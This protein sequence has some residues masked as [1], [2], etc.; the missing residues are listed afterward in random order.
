M[1]TNEVTALG[2]TTK[3]LTEII[4][5]LKTAFRAIYGADINVDQNSPD[6]Q[7]INIMAQLDSDLLDLITQVY[8]SFDPDSAEGATLDARVAINGLQRI[9]GTYTIAPVAVTVDRA[10]TLDGLDSPNTPFTVADATGTQFYLETT[11]VI[12]V[13]GTAEYNFRAKDLGAVQVTPNTITT[14][15][16]IVIGVTAVNNPN[17]VGTLGQDEE[18]DADLKIRRQASL[19]GAATNSLDSLYTLL[20]NTDGV[21]DALVWENYTSVPDIYGVPGHTI[22]PIIE[23]GAAA[24]IALD[25]Y[26]KRSAGCGMYGSVSE[27]VLQPNGSYFTIYFDRPI[28]VPIYI[29]FYLTPR[30]P[31]ATYDPAT[32]KAALAA[33]LDFTIFKVAD[34]A[35]IT[36]LLLDIVPSHIPTG[37]E[38]ST[39]NVNWFEILTPSTPQEKFTVDAINITIL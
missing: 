33:Q 24:D 1:T 21:T 15:V 12:A 34:N 22:W 26:A 28:Y 2:L 13:P 10:I 19:A 8:N 17:P 30:S 27:D 38:I 7:M 25:I 14:Q 16:T 31:S 3:P 18:T 23:G 4:D 5:D 29:H 6:G 39:D 11:Q 37:V 20:R 36:G 32:V 9:G 35:D